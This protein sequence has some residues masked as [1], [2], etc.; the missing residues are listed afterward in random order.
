MEQ[1]KNA[2]PQVAA[3]TPDS[4]AAKAIYKCWGELKMFIVL[5]IVVASVRA[6]YLSHKEEQEKT[7]AMEREQ[8][9]IDERRKQVYEKYLQDTKPENNRG[10]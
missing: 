8:K 1:P 7:E 6:I 9:A 3:P 2:Q 4:L 10:W 5:V